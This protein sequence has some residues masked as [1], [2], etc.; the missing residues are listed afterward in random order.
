MIIQTVKYSKVTG[1]VNQHGAVL[2]CSDQLRA[3][4]RKLAVPDFV[5]VLSEIV[6]DLQWEVVSV[7]HV[8]RVKRW[9]I[10][11]VVVQTVV[12]LALF[13]VV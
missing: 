13:H 1:V 4:M 10:S 7:T 2:A 6:G 8:V 12:N 9:W 11:S 3:I 5:G